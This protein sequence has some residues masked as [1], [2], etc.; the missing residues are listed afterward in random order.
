MTHQTCDKLA[1]MMEQSLLKLELLQ[2]IG[3]F[4]HNLIM[5][6]IGNESHRV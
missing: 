4:A 3:L 5:Q 6:G 2:A 1:S